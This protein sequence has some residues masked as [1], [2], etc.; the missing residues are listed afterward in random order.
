MYLSETEDITHTC[1]EA[2]YN[3]DFTSDGAADFQCFVVLFYV[4]FNDLRAVRNFMCPPTRGMQT[5]DL[6]ER[7]SCP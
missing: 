6:R 5:E 7:L 4:K 1:A 3:V 2:T